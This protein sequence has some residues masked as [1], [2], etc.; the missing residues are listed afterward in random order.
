MKRSHRAVN[1]AHSPAEDQ[2]GLW[3][4][5]GNLHAVDSYE[6]TSA[7]PSL[8]SQSACSISPLLNVL[9]VCLDI[10]PSL[11]LFQNPMLIIFPITEV[12]AGP[13]CMSSHHDKVIELVGAL[14]WLGHILFEHLR[15]EAMECLP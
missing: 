2:Q 14:V 1:L 10:T 7:C 6:H 15:S 8:S 12:A 9:P 5:I 4:G 11:V 3:I 13:D